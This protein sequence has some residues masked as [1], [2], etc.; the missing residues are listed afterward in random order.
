MNQTTLTFPF[1]LHPGDIRGFRAAI[2][3]Q[4]GLGHRLFHGH[5]NSQPDETKYSNDYPLVRFCTHKGRAQIVGMGAG[6]DAIIRHL[7]PVIPTTLVF[8]KQPHDT[9]GWRLGTRVWEPK[10]LTEY[11]SFGLYQW[12]AL[13]SENYTA[14]KEHD[15]KES[16]RRL[17]LDRCLTGHLRAL[18]ETAGLGKEQR[19][20]IVARVLRQDKVKKLNWHNT[21]LIGFNVVAEAN[22]LPPYGLGLGRCHSFGFG[23][24]CSERNYAALTQLKKKPTRNNDRN[25]D[26]GMEMAI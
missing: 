16:A 13:N 7:L 10:I 19:S 11:Q 15:G 17:I 4:L 22:F 5:D 2:V 26:D 9:A 8:A 25:P 3:E 1:H 18:G 14:W 12:V 20:R 6:A 21:Q 23:E 24:V